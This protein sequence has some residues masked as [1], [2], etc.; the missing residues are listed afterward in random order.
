[1]PRRSSPTR[2]ADLV[3]AATRVFIA[4]GYRRTQMADVAAELGVAKGTVYLSV[5]SKEALFDRVLRCADGGGGVAAAPKRLPVRAPRRGATLA[6]VRERLTREPLVADIMALGARRRPA[7]LRT[8]L[9]TVL[10]KVYDVLSANRIGIKL[11]DRCAADHPGLG[12]LWFRGGRQG[13]LAA[14]REY[15]ESRAR[16]KGLRHFQDSEVVARIVLETLVFWA[17]HRHWDPSPMAIEEAVAR[18]TAIGFLS[19][20]LLAGRAP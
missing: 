6:Y 11:V 7:D 14:L 18:S 20:A 3:A 5:E 2:L 10:G 17:V 1:M 4:Q 16:T 9:E 19:A 15:F 13:I 8:E 12:D